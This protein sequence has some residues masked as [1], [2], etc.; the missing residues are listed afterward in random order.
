MMTKTE[1]NNTLQVKLF[2]FFLCVYK[3]IEITKGMRAC[4]SY[5]HFFSVS[6]FIL[7][8]EGDRRHTD[9]CRTSGGTD[10]ISS[11]FLR[12][13]LAL[14]VAPFSALIAYL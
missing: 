5:L 9:I 3:N 14:E 12:E 11:L 4:F 8:K 10:L 1:V 7:Q 13:M 2:F 6:H